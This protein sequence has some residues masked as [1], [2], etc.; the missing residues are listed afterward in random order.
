[1]KTMK[2]LRSQAESG[3]EGGDRGRSHRSGNSVHCTGC[4]LF[5]EVGQLKQ[6]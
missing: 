5:V 4:F 2:N 3:N 1:M 6:R